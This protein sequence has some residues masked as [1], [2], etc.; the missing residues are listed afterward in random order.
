[1]GT[2]SNESKES[3]PKQK[4]FELKNQNNKLKASKTD[5]NKREG[6]SFTLT[7]FAI[8]VEVEAFPALAPV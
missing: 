1:M 5:L 8:R 2:E 7:C 3:K 4:S 6:F